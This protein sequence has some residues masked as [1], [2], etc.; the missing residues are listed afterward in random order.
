MSRITQRVKYEI[1]ALL[2]AIL[3]FGTW[4]GVLMLVK[5]LILAEY[6]IEFN[7]WS[8]AVV[9]VLAPVK[10]VLILEHVSLGDWV[11]NQPAWLDV[12]LCTTLYAVGMLAVLVLEK[13]FEGRHEYVGF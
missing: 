4:V 6:Q 2:L 10:V 9:G 13:A 3:Y 8:L 11:R 1:K 5:A 7:R 12:L